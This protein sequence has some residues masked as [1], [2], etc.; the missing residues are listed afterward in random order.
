MLEGLSAELRLCKGTQIIL[1]RSLWSAKG[2]AKGSMETVT[3]VIY[4]PHIDDDNSN[5]HTPLC[6]LASFAKYT[7]PKLFDNLV[8]I[9][10]STLAF[11]NGGVYPDSGRF[12]RCLRRQFRAQH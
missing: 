9:L 11:K 4:D 10:P 1:R 6:T 7:G 5:E 2:F 3:E 8:P 12:A